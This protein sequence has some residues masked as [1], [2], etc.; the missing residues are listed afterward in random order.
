M[1][2]YS[3]M[4]SINDYNVMYSVNDYK[5]LHSVNDYSVMYSINDYNVMKCVNDYIVKVVIH[6]ENAQSNPQKVHL[7]FSKTRDDIK[8]N[9]QNTVKLP[10]KYQFVLI[11]HKINC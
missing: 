5:G 11:K 9:K 4:Y 10:Q 6:V 3:V 2:D 8:W 1:N 7:S